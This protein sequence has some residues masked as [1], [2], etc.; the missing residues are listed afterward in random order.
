MMSDYLL[1]EAHAADIKTPPTAR[2]ASISFIL[3]AVLFLMFDR[4]YPRKTLHK[5]TPIS[6]ASGTKVT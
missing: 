4:V 3:M 5:E 6:L 1:H 2:T